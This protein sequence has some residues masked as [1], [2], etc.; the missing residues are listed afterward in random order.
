M[1]RIATEVEKKK[2]KQK[3]KTNNNNNNNKQ[4]HFFF[5]FRGIKSRISRN[6]IKESSENFYKKYVRVL[7]AYKVSL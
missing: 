5:F 3:K 6:E 7:L 1:R 4:Q 2:K